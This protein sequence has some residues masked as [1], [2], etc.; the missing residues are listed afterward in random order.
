MTTRC[1]DIGMGGGCGVSCE[2]FCDGECLEPQEAA[3]GDII[4]EYGLE[5][6]LEIMSQY[7]CFTEG[8]H[9]TISLGWS[10]AKARFL[11]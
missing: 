4:A 3:R 1:D 2:A 11:L 6:A 10:D 9:L 7:D 5:E 8:K